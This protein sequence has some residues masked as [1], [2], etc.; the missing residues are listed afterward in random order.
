MPFLLLPFRPNVDVS[1]AKLF[2]RNYFNALAGNG[3][4]ASEEDL[5]RELRLTEPAVRNHTPPP[6]RRSHTRPARA[7]WRETRRNP[8]K[9]RDHGS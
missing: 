4:Y 8:P 1:A 2:V 6:A 7:R 9:N 5:Q 3:A